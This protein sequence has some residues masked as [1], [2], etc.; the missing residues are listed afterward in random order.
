M[1]DDTGTEKYTVHNLQDLRFDFKGNTS[2]VET[3]QE[4]LN[5]TE[6]RGMEDFLGKEQR[7]FSFLLFWIS[8]PMTEKC[9]LRPWQLSKMAIPAPVKSSLAYLDEKPTHASK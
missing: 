8:K 5:I 3:F 2:P 4:K 9:H 6:A 7:C 1:E